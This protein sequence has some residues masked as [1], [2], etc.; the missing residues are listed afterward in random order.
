[1]TVEERLEYEKRVRMRQAVIAG[2]AGVLI[3]IAAVVQ[4]TG[5]QASVNELT[6]GLIYTHKRVPRD[7]IGSAINMLGFFAA[8]ATLAYLFGATRAR[9][10]ALKTWMKWVTI[11]GAVLAGVIGVVYSVVLATKASDFVSHGTQTYQEANHLTKSPVLVAL[12]LI[13][14]LGALLLAVGFLLTS[15]NAMRV[16]LLTRFMGYLG[17]FT[18]VLVLFPIGSP[19]PVVQAY[20][21]FALAYL[22]SGRWP[23]GVPPAW[24]SGRA[25]PW[26]SSQEMREQRIRA[27]AGG[28]GPAKPQT[29][30]APEA[31]AASSTARTRSST[32]KRKRKR[33]K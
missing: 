33:R 10:P 13:G 9:N 24:G 23:T 18:G 31:V 21:L 3:V 11:A 8:G 5:P 15:L 17:V 29:T 32:P 16:G 19:I 7:Q 12:P 30:P 1:M 4:V 2:L 26:P 27:A 14:Q 28:R 25:E 20:W 22:L 6:L